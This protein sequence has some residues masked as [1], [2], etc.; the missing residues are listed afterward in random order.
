MSRLSS[1][2]RSGEP[3]CAAGLG[4]I[5]AV[6]D[7]F[8]EMRLEFFVDLAA[9]GDRREECWRC[10]TERDIGLLRTQAF[11]PDRCARRGSPRAARPAAP[12][13]EW[14]ARAARALPGLSASP[15]RAATA[16]YRAAA[17]PR[18]RPAMAPYEHHR[19]DVRGHA[20]RDVAR[21]ARR[22]PCGCRFRGAAAAPNN[23]ARRRGRCRRATAP[24]RRRTAPASPAG[25]RGRCAIRSISICVRMLLTRNSGRARGTSWRRI[26]ASASGLA[27]GGAD[28]ERAAG[29]GLK[30]AVADH[31]ERDISGG[32]DGL[33]AC[34]RGNARRGPGPL[35]ESERWRLVRATSRTIFR[36]GS[37]PLKYCLAKASL[38]MAAPGVRSRSRRKSLPARS[39]IRMVS[40]Q[41]G[42]TFRKSKSASLGGAP[43]T[44]IR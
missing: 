7:G 16:M 43:L 1:R 9:Q 13:R 38:T 4:G 23:P 5:A 28:D 33:G 22:S 41:P 32:T 31:G 35:P 20:P 21:P 27:L 6:L 19:E 29:G 26:D 37:A 40:S 24:R 11:E 8:G 25:A 18:A 17:I 42:E 15:G 2:W 30:C 44:E 34:C 14:S 10:G 36:P 12:P 39:G 3:K